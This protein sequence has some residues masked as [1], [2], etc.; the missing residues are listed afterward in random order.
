MLFI[1]EDL[2]QLFLKKAQEAYFQG[3]DKK[4][5]FY[6]TQAKDYMKKAL[7]IV[8]INFSKDSLHVERIKLKLNHLIF[9]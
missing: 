6:L 4:R 5:I 7:E 1:L 8:E 2:S 3:E 9:N